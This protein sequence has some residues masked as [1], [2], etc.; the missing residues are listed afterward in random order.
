MRYDEG[1]WVRPFGAAEGAGFGWGEGVVSGEILDGSLRW[2]NAPRRRE[3][4]VWTPNLRGVIKTSDGAEI[5]VA[6]HGQSVEEATAGEARRAILARVELVTEHERYRWL[7]TSFLVGEGEIDQDT[8]A[9]W[10]ETYV[11]INE[12]VA[13][14]PAIGSVPPA[15]FKQAPREDH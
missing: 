4:G 5:L 15:R 8:E 3:D 7:N 1:T 13:H 2:A 11:C 6:V 10:I 9:W 14:P 12:V